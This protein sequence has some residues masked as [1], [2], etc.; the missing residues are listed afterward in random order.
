MFYAFLRSLKNL[1]NF[2]ILLRIV[3]EKRKLF[4]I[5]VEGVS[6]D[7]DRVFKKVI[8]IPEGSTFE[9]RIGCDAVVG[10]DG[11]IQKVYDYIP[12]CNITKTF[13]YRKKRR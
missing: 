4:Y 13:Y 5:F 12:G 7:G 3:P 6:K 2:D 8:P 10:A 1:L 9:M 11:R